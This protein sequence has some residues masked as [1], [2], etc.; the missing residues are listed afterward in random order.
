MR[1]FCCSRSCHRKRFNFETSI[2]SRIRS[3][4]SLRSRFSPAPPVDQIHSACPWL[5]CPSRSAPPALD[6]GPASL[7][8]RSPCYLD[9]R[10]QSPHMFR[11]KSSPY[12][13]A[14]A[15]L[16]PDFNPRVARYVGRGLRHLHFHESR[17]RVFPQPF[18][19]PVKMRR[20]QL[21]HSAERRHTLPA[22]HLFGNQSAPLRPCISASFSLRHRATLLCDDHLPQ[23]ALHVALTNKRGSCCCAVPLPSS[24]IQ[25]FSLP[26][27][28]IRLLL[29]LSLR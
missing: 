12:H 16:Q 25:E 19:P 8:A 20:A 1:C 29:L 5:R 15:I 7:A 24:P 17:C 9:H 14:P 2:P 11:I 13:Q 22:P 3:A 28:Q 23:D 18:L 6:L 27:C 21:P 4:G 26:E 10:Q